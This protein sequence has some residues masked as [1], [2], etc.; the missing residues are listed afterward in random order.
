ME[1]FISELMSRGTVFEESGKSQRK[2]N[3]DK[4]GEKMCKFTTY[5][6]MHSLSTFATQVG[7]F[8]E[9]RFQERNQSFESVTHHLT[10]LLHIAEQQIKY[11]EHL[12][13]I[14]GKVSSLTFVDF[15][16]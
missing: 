13:N 5:H 8:Q 3:I 14:D 4:I 10:Q 11:L 9:Q 12:R 2:S 16:V 1:G 7:E 6:L 15:I